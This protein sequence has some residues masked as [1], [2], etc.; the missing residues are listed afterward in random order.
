MPSARSLDATRLA[1][2]VH[3]G[4]HGSISAAARVL[5]LT[6]SAVSQQ[7]S[8]LE[9]ECGVPLIERR[10]KGVA[11]TDAGRVLRRRAEE[12]VRVME[13]AAT[14]MAQLHG[15][16]AGQVRIASIGSAAAYL[17]LPAISLLRR[18]APE[19]SMHVSILEPDASIDAL[20]EGRLDLAVID[21]YDHVPVPLPS[22][23][24]ADDLVTEPLVLV[25]AREAELPVEPRLSELRD[26]DWVL[27]PDAAA[28]GAATRYACRMAGFDPLVRWETDDLLLLVAA[29]SR[30]EGVALL[31]RRAIAD[32]VAPVSMRRL[33]EPTLRRRISVVS[34]FGTASRPAVDIC[35]QALREIARST[36]H[37]SRLPAEVPPR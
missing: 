27:P 33:A 8:A 6:P 2:L 5:G 9:S 15:E 11:L 35:Q 37:L 4:R 22:D 21:T 16:V 30:G 18:N 17:L 32:S 28:C 36:E 31:P 29:V 20:L 7:M 34:R 26:A 1:T 23:L 24:V 12:V 14:T 10:A 25:S 3:V 13:T 19:V